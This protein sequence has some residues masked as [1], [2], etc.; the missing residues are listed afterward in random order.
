M[1]A[2]L[3]AI[4]LALGWLAVVGGFTLPNLLL[5]L[6]IAVFVIFLLR[7]RLRQP[8]SL[9]K[10]VA[11]LSLALFFLRELL[12]SAFAV[13]RLAVSPALRSRLSPAIVA[14]PLTVR[15]EAEITLLANLITLTPGTLTIDVAADHTCLYVHALTLRS[16]QALVEAIA[17]GLEKRIIEVF[18]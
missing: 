2:G 5:G 9:R 3:L 10:L 4:V 6:A 1:S 14:F 12:L 7:H 15:S 8:V 17:T 13:A 18:R 11:I 16:R